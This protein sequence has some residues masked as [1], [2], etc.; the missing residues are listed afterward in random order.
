MLFPL[1]KPI[2]DMFYLT[3]YK[4]YRY[5]QCMMSDCT[6]T[7]YYDAVQSK[8]IMLG[9]VIYINYDSPIIK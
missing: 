8:Q 6:S 1:E 2:T 3:I 4:Q 5:N 7:R 9:M